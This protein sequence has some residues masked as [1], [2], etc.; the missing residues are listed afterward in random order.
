MKYWYVYEKNQDNEPYLVIENDELFNEFFADGH[1]PPEDDKYR[2]VE[3]SENEF[4]IA[5]LQ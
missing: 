2:W 5:Q 3:L 4:K 1:Y